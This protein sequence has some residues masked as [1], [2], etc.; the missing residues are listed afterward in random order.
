MFSKILIAN[1][2]EI[3]V[4]IIKVCKELG[5]KTVAVY[6][7]AEKDSL[8]SLLADESY[9]IGPAS[10]KNSYMN[11][12]ALISVAISTQSDAIHPGYGFHSESFEFAKRCHD[13][14]ITFIGPSYHVINNVSNKFSIKQIA[15]S[16]AVPVANASLINNREEIKYNASQIGYPIILKIL[17]GG[18]GAGIKVIESQED[19]LLENCKLSSNNDSG[20]YMEQYFE[21]VKHI[22]VQILG[23][24]YGNILTLGDRDCSIQKDN[25]KVIEECTATSI[26]SQLREKLYDCS[27]RIAKAVQYS[28]A[29]TIEFLVDEKENFY[30]MEFNARLQVEHGITE[31]VTGIDIVKWQIKIAAGERLNINQEE[32]CCRGHAIECRINAL[33]FGN[34]SEFQTVNDDSIRFD[35]MITEN[36]AITPYY[37]P[38]IGKLMI[39]GSNRVQAIDKMK[40]ALSEMV[41]SGIQTNIG[42]LLKILSNSTFLQGTYLTDF[43]DCELNTRNIQRVRDRLY[44]VVDTN[45]FEEYF[46][47]MQS[48]NILGFKDYDKKLEKAKKE[49]GELEAVI[50]GI[51]KVG[52]Y[53]CVI[54]VMDPL[55]MLGS[56]GT[57]VGEKITKA[58]ELAIQKRLPVVSICASGG[59]RMQEG[60]FSLFQ[61]A[62]T[63]AVVKRHSQQGLL[64]ISV[65]S[66][67]TLGG[68]S[69][70]FASL[71][72]IIIGEE[73][74]V[75]GFTG[76]RIIEE[77]FKRRTSTD[78]QTVEYAKKHGQLDIITSKSNVRKLLI[79]ILHFHRTAKN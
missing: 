37:D 78:F 35:H 21:K 63:S 14:N 39:Y 8:H 55:F 41:I 38:L 42:I 47:E 76:K 36:I 24:D 4:K 32:V 54:F 10:V 34:I 16:L 64:Y 68:V 2:G 69:A 49:S 45:S 25:K 61:M 72:D 71:A 30:F 1:R 13:Y 46:N 5:V 31:M 60:V 58:F 44:E 17:N 75:Y 22:E 48:R 67:P 27:L 70:S 12:E 73:D 28:N 9:C 66:N 3:A 79:Q 57:I 11:V 15:E 65:I 53:R 43:M 29:G 20:F 26:S 77:T 50:S 40:K 33:S 18:G 56:M 23:D 7:S 6:S 74:A 52:N 51:A 19:L 59:A 62:K